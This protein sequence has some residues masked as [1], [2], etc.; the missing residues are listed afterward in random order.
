MKSPSVPRQQQIPDKSIEQVG[1]LC[2]IIAKLKRT[3]PVNSPSL[4]AM[5]ASLSGFGLDAVI[6]EKYI[7]ETIRSSMGRK[8]EDLHSLLL[9]KEEARRNTDNRLIR[10]RDTRS[11]QIHIYRVERQQ[12][13]FDFPLYHDQ[14]D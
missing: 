1:A 2:Q 11:T 9:A 6:Y 10:K 3:R 5:E 7:G 12:R 14:H 13:V 8:I 4:I